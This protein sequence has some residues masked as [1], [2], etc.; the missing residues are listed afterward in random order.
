MRR[1][2]QRAVLAAAALCLGGAL[3]ACGGSGDDDGYAAVGAGAEGSPDGAVPPKGEIEL[4]PLEPGSTSATPSDS[5]GSGSATPPS[6]NAGPT[7]TPSS[8]GSG[9]S[10]SGATPGTSSGTSGSSG[11]SGAPGTSPGAPSAP[12]APVRPG[13]RPPSTAPAPTPR[14]PAGPAVLAVG[15]PVRKGLDKRW[16]EEVTVEFRNSGGTAVTSGTATFETHV[17]GALGVDWATVETSQPLPAP[18]AAGAKRSQT[19]TVCVDAWRV[20]LGMRIET[21][22]VTA[23]W[24]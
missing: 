19:Y 9:T 11:S 6:S 10:S 22:D 5:T 3:T 13:A 1:R 23:A 21:Q 18:I 17:I 15:D 24:K 7:P 12:S 14:P 16:C 2:R 4:I 20:P 8:G